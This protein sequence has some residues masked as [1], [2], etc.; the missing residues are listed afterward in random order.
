MTAKQTFGKPPTQKPIA[1]M[2]R[3]M[4]LNA[5]PK[6]S[7]EIPTKKACHV[8][9]PTEIGEKW[10]LGQTESNAKQPGVATV[11]LCRAE[12]P[13]PPVHSSNGVALARPIN[14]SRLDKRIAVAWC[15]MLDATA[16]EAQTT[17]AWPVRGKPA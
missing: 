9:L 16:V 4:P 13:A 8:F 5:I 14:G 2:T 17:N 1:S 12:G 6:P 15:L 10:T 3:R 11:N 7:R